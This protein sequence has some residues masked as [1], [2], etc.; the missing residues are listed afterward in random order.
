MKTNHII[1]ALI[2]ILFIWV[3]VS[4][5]NRNFEYV[6]EPTGTYT[7]ERMYLQECRTV[8]RSYPDNLVGNIDTVASRSGY[9]GLGLYFIYTPITVYPEITKRKL[10]RIKR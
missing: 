2:S 8:S 9:W 10:R 5:I 3:G 4:S 1:F 6:E 7:K